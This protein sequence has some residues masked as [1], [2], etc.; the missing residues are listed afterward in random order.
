MAET[1]NQAATATILSP[2]A[3]P[4]V[5]GQTVTFTAT[6]T[7]VAPGAGPPTGTVTLLDGNTVLGTAAVGADG[8]ATL[9]TSFAAAGGH[10]ITAIYSG[11]GNFVGQL[12][13][14]RGA[15]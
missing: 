6:V 11:D 3:N 8:W 10:A 7:A 5:G 13:G 12:A 14:R 9:A 4:A 15:G 1:V 2:S